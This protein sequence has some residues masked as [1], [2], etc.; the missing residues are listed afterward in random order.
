M[1]VPEEI[2]KVPR[3]RNTVV[4]PSTTG[5]YPVRERLGCRYEVTEDGRRRRVPVEGSVI[6]HIID[7]VYVSVDDEIPPVGGIG[8]VD[9]KD[10]ANVFLCDRLNSDVLDDLGLFY[11][12]EEAVRI[13]VIAILRG[14]YNGIRD[15]LLERQY[16]ETF[17]TEMYPDV[18]LSKNKVCEFQR[19][20]GRSCNRIVGFTKHRIGNLDEDDT[21][22][23]DGTLQVN[24]SSVNSLSAPSRRT[25][26]TRHCDIVVMY[27]YSA[28][29]REPVCSRCY[30]GNMVDKRI[31]ADFI[32]GIGL[33][34]G[35]VVADKGFILSS[36]IEALADRQGVG[37]VIPLERNDALVKDN[38]VFSYDGRLEGDRGILT[39]KIHLED[40]GLWLYSFRDPEKAMEQEMLFNLNTPEG[41]DKDGYHSI[42]MQFGNVVF[43]SNRDLECCEVYRIYDDRWLIET[44]FKFRKGEMDIDDT[45]VH[46][47][48]SVI[49]H[50]FLDFL[51]T[52]FMSR[53]YN[54]LSQRGVLDKRTFGQARGLL[55]RA[56]MVRVPNGEWSIRRMAKVD[57][58]FLSSVGLISKPMEPVEKRKRGRPKGSRDTKPRK[59]RSDSESS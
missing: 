18:D 38:D 35:L 34:S 14:C 6:G 47:D 40:K 17:L 36:I 1:A 30:P 49:G 26:L 29:R 45:R 55:E 57:A 48:Y 12:R 22:I 51:A 58:E 43:A 4:L 59:K 41:F 46:S 24:D 50:E 42:K 11:N 53:V 56:K 15:S 32:D 2:R 8:E 44:F 10:W 5:R 28:G 54:F 52:L 37:F 20:L 31:V 21:V 16:E 7:G 33:E 19:N 13:Y 25:H 9:V 27:A 23:I 39:R 3:P